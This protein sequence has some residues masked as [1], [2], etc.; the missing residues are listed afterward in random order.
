MCIYKVCILYSVFKVYIYCIV[1]TKCVYCILYIKYVYCIVYIKYV[2]NIAANPIFILR[3]T[4]SV[5]TL[6]NNY[7]K[8][9]D[10]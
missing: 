1:Y 7:V 10:P 5:T 4:L 8:P 9:F 6:V 2:I 3:C